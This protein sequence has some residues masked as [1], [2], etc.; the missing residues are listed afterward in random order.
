VKGARSAT[1]KLPR[2]NG[3][4]L[5]IEAPFEYIKLFQLVRVTVH[6]RESARVDFHQKCFVAPCDILE[7]GFHP[8]TLGL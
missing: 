1:A 2:S 3:R 5:V 8:E 6:R 4:V 7:Q